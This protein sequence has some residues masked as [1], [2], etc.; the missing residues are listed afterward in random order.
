ML[1]YTIKLSLSVLFFNFTNLIKKYLKT[2]KDWKH[3]RRSGSIHFTQTLSSWKH[4]N[5][6]QKRWTVK[7]ADEHRFEVHGRMLQMLCTRRR[8]LS[9]HN[10]HWHRNWVPKRPWVQNNCLDW[11][12]RRW[13][14]VS[15]C[16]GYRIRKSYQTSHRV[17]HRNLLKYV[18]VGHSIW[19]C[20]CSRLISFWDCNCNFVAKL[21]LKVRISI[22]D[23]FVY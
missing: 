23:N 11:R 10:L 3:W 16:R 2:W 21:C 6:H 4:R 22:L 5:R 7:W 14:W 19:P 9:L 13:W 17:V 15:C 20:W 18:F 12:N 1:V 8:S